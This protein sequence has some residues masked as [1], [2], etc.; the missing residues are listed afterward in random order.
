MLSIL[1]QKQLDAVQ[2]PVKWLSLV[3]S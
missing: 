3:L 2:S 1:H